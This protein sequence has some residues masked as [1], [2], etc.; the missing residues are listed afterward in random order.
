MS[1]ARDE[2]AD[3]RRAELFLPTWLNLLDALSERPET[4]TLMKDLLSAYPHYILELRLERE[5]REEC[6]ARVKEL[7]LV[8]AH[9][10]RNEH[11]PE[12]R[13]QMREKLR[14]ILHF[15]EGI[16]D[17]ALMATAANVIDRLRDNVAALASLADGT[18]GVK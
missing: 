4:F 2:E 7:E 17:S 12:C 15:G 6:E 3:H 11:H 14:K 13:F 1:A 18:G 10:P 8:N 16:D 5:R 9:Y